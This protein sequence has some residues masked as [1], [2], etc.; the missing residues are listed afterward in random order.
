[1]KRAIRCWL[2]QNKD[3]KCRELAKSQ[4][5]KEAENACGVV[6]SIAVQLDE[7]RY[8][9]K[10]R[11]N[12]FLGH[13]LLRQKR[14]PDAIEYYNRAL[15]VVGT[16]LTEKD[17]ELGRL[18]GDLA[19]AYHL[20]R[21]LGRARELYKKAERI[22]QTAYSTFGDG[23][24]DEFVQRIKE[25]YLKALKTL[26]EYH[27]SAAEDA[28][29][30][31]EAEDIRK[32]AKSLKGY[33]QG[34]AW[35]SPQNLGA[36]I[37]SSGEETCAMVSPDGRYLFFTSNRKLPNTEVALGKGLTY[38]TMLERLNGLGRGRWHIYYVGTDSAGIK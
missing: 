26:L 4:D 13:V 20:M 30:I 31:S 24:S 2:V 8:L 9:E 27:L 7:D 16:R 18:W 15:I 37:N 32:L 12:E 22:Y 14:Y 3:K 6:L 28:G 25:G 38:P 23:D 1:M 29:A 11:A 5:L 19:I 35:S 36:P 17:A 10:M 21:D 33:S 34:G